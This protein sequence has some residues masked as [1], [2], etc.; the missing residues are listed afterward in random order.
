MHT[1][2]MLIT[3]LKFIGIVILIITVAVFCYFMYLDLKLGVN[4]KK[5]KFWRR[6]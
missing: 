1:T 2:D 6:R 4:R 3:D 5:K